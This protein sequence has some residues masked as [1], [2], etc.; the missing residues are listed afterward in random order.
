MEWR[1]IQTVLMID[2]LRTLSIQE[3]TDLGVV[4]YAR[5]SE[6]GLAVLHEWTSWL[7]FHRIILDHDLGGEDTIRPVIERF[8]STIGQAMENLG[9]DDRSEMDN[10]IANVKA[11]TNSMPVIEIVTSNPAGRIYLKAFAERY[12]QRIVGA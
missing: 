11:H 10:F 12:F 6:A 8:E 5:T 9:L 4:T 7:G 1:M 2:D 3:E